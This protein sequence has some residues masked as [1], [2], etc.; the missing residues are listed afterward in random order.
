M[1]TR[2]QSLAKTSPTTSI[3]HDKIRTLLASES[4]LSRREIAERLGLSLQSVCGRIGELMKSGEVRTT[5]TK[6]DTETDRVVTIL[7]LV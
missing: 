6:N 4:D 1:N 7:S 5:G 3:L 2:S